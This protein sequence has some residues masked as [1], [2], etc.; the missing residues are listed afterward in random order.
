MNRSSG[1]L[2]PISSL[3]SNYGIGTLGKEAYKFVDFLCE[4]N[5][6][7]W[8]ILPL[9]PVSFGDSPYSS[10]SSFAGN[11]Y[12]I[13]LD[14]LVDE[15]LLKRSDLKN[16]KVKNKNSIDYL[17]LFE[18][19]YTILYKAYLNGYKKDLKKVNTFINENKWVKDFALYMSIKRYFKNKSWQEWPDN[20]IRNRET[21]AINKYK[22]L[23]SDKYN[24]HIYVQ[25]LFYKQFNQLK[26]Y[27]NK[28]GIKLIGDIP[29]YVPLDSCD[30][31]ANQNC[32]VLDKNKIP[33]EVA[34]VPPDYFSSNGQLWG[35]PIYDWKYLKKD[36]YK[37][38]IERLRFAG[39]LYDVVRIDH[40]RG[41]E[42][43]WAVP[44][45]EKTA[46]H[47]RWVKGPNMDFLSI[48]KKKLN[49]VE[50]ISEDLGYHTPAVSKMLKDFGFPGMKV[51]QFGF[52]SRNVSDQAPHAYSKN[53]ICY[54]GTHDNSTIMGWKKSVKKKDLEYAKKYLGLNNSEGYNWGF[55]RAGMSSVAILF[56]AQIQDYLGLDDRTRINIPGTLGN[57]WKWRM[58]K[59]A[60]NKALANKISNYTHMYGR[61][62]LNVHKK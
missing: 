42:S 7:Y 40:F 1:I 20:S 56:V 11:P 5:Q 54:T 3:P 27:M 18:T 58:N 60:L 30:C 17:Y 61:D 8:Q 6:T 25:Y 51:L 62:N 35:N 39:S 41:L 13:D 43:F 15:K 36:N 57:N 32:F 44:Y 2:L 38:W 55:I 46:K 10:F 4:A 53:Y 45:G 9:G 37:W 29:I 12:Y 48:V 14:K 34:G 23:L 22:R 24:F 21:K 59:N 52:D 47:G 19:R 33:R 49:K 28:K 31:W 50:F 26:N 16:I